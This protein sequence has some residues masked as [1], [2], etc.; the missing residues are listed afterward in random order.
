MAQRSPA[1]HRRQ[2][3]SELRRLRD[4][5]GRTCADVAAR[6][7]WSESKLSRVETAKIAIRSSDLEQLLDEYGVSDMTVRTKLLSLNERARKRAWWEAYGDALAADN[8]YETYIG[9]ESDALSISIFQSSVVPGL[10]QTAEYA[11]AVIQAAA[12]P[13]IGADMLEARVAA[14]IARQAILARESPPNLAVLLDEA[15]LRRRVGGSEVMQR[16]IDRLISSSESGSVDL[17]VL[18][19]STGAHRCIS[20]SFV[21]LE[22]EGFG[23]SGIVYNEGITNATIHRRDRD[24]LMYKESFEDAQNVALDTEE[25]L[26]YLANL[27]VDAK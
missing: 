13:P 26:R 18:P 2:L 8:A 24:I 12:T 3:G 20:E 27:R 15:V 7:G 6:L 21:I 4:H 22:L 9:L 17:A 19:F 25:S 23:G 1:A 16:Q 11:H 5:V 14:R 10:L